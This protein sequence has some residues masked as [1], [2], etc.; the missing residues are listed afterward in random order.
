MQIFAGALARVTAGEGLEPDISG[1]G[2]RIDAQQAPNL[3]EGQALL[4][5]E[6]EENR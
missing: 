2:F 6:M 3:V 1:G 4:P 5:V